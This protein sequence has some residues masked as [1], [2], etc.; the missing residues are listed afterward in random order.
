M[1]NDILKE[2][3]YK[4]Q[5]EQIQALFDISLEGADYLAQMGERGAGNPEAEAILENLRE[6]AGILAAEIDGTGL[7]RQIHLYAKNI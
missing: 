2:E 3:A 5:A 4:M 6:I 1:T 7:R